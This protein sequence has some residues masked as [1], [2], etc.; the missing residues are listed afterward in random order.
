METKFTKSEAVYIAGSNQDQRNWRIDIYENG[1]IFC[2]VFGK[3]R[4]HAEENAK[5]V[6][7]ASKLFNSC[8]SF[9]EML[10]RGKAT[11]KATEGFESEIAQLFRD[12]IEAINKA[13]E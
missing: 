4:D 1:L 3:T 7:A 2:T 11:I 10:A 9:N 12:N 6:C 8:A 5:L 13:T